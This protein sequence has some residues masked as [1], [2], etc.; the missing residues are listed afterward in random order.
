MK[1]FYVHDIVFYLYK[2]I[3]SYICWNSIDTFGLLKT[4]V[5]IRSSTGTLINKRF[6]GSIV[7]QE[8][9]V[10]KKTITLTK[11]CLVFLVPN[12]Q[13]RNLHS[14]GKRSVSFRSGME[15]FRE[16]RLLT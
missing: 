7:G 6:R 10:C 13:L 15:K 1:E 3:K 4:S 16:S 12:D 2:L 8:F 9:V 14:A 11:S 5:T